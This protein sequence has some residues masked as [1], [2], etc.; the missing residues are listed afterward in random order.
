M[1]KVYL[2]WRVADDH[3]STDDVSRN[4]RSQKYSIRIPE[5]G[6]LFNHVG[7]IAG[8]DETDAEVVS[9]LYDSISTKPVPTD[10]VAA[11]AASQSYATAR[12]ACISIAH[13][14]VPV[15]VVVGPA[16]DDNPREAIGG[17][18]HA[19]DGGASA[20]EEPDA[21][22]SKLF[23][24]TRSTNVDAHLGVD[25]N[26][27]LRSAASAVTS[28]LRVGLSGHGEAVQFQRHILRTD[29]NAGRVSDYASDVVYQLAILGDGQCFGNRAADI[30]GVCAASERAEKCG[31]PGNPLST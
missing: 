16:D 6:V 8:T 27:Y 12:I 11:G 2:H 7:G 18:G 10:P 1:V 14:K 29:G 31:K 25:V 23:H 20:V 30:R 19:R 28:R 24:E 3:V 21:V 13:G 4:S 22:P 5:D 17:S 26:P 9:L 15:E